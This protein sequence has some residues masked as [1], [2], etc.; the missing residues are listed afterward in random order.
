MRKRNDVENLGEFVV[1]VG[2]PGMSMCL[3]RDSL[4]A[5]TDSQS[6]GYCGYRWGK[7]FVADRRAK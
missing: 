6:P 4:D 3:R 7:V 1:V 2:E 5:R